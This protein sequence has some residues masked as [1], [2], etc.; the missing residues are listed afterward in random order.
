MEI[1]SAQSAGFCFGVKRAVE[2][3][4]EY[5][6][7]P[8]TFTYGPIIHNEVVIGALEKKG[9]YAIDTLEGHEVDKLII[10]SHGVSPEIYE[11]GK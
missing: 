4:Y 2:M 10:R 9:V 11:K 1:V 3:A 8:H 5:Q 7:T 6:D